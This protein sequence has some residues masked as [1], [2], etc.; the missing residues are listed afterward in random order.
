[1]PPAAPEDDTMSIAQDTDFQ[2]PVQKRFEIDPSEA[3]VCKMAVASLVFGILSFV[4]LPGVG[5]IVAVILGHVALGE[6]RASQGRLGGRS[7][8]RAGLALGY[9]NLLAVAVLALVFLWFIPVGTSTRKESIVTRIVSQTDDT[10]PA[11][12]AAV[13][14]N[15]RGVKMANEMGR[16]DFD[17][18]K[19]AGLESEPDEI[20]A[21]SN[22][23][24]STGE[25]ELALLTTRQL[26]YVK[27]GRKTT[28]DLKDVVAIQS[29]T[30]LERRRNEEGNYLYP[31]E[32]SRVNG[33]RM[34]IWIESQEQGK[35]FYDALNS[36]WKASKDRTEPE[37]TRK[38]GER[39]SA[40]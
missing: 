38:A 8:A 31:I 16:R 34:R 3:P 25:P 22:A 13:R 10:T 14:G 17:L 21:F 9:L 37:P 2:D 35:S 26:I 12:L 33:T 27:D 20:I 39:P 5:A 18:L 1:M 28:F 6:V 7:A 40:P 23:S 30:Q 4:A 11:T 15:N 19:K 29:G 36:A 24:E 32:A